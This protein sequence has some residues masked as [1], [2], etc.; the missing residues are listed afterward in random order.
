M[1]RFSLAFFLLC[2]SHPAWASLSSCAS[3]PGT[4]ISSLGGGCAKTDLNFTSLTLGTETGFTNSPTTGNIDFGASG[5]VISGT[6]STITPIDA[7]WTSP[8]AT[9]S[10]SG[11][12]WYVQSSSTHTATGSVGFQVT[13]N[14]G[15]AGSTPVTPAGDFWIINSL[16][17]VVNAGNYGTSSSGSATIVEQFCLNATTLAGCS[18]AKS[19]SI[20]ATI[21]AN[22]A[23]PTF[24]WQLGAF[25]GSGNSINLIAD[26]AN[27]VTSLYILDQVTLKNGGYG[28]TLS[29][30][31]A[32]SNQFDQTAVAPEPAPYLLLGTGLIGFA[33]LGRR[34]LR[35][36]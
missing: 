30:L 22:S 7:T 28:T 36:R 26:F 23:L 12:G 34:Q 6:P 35:R 10:P 11:N 24:T 31:D 18:S 1:K 19:G 25:S 13:G 9:S 17:L 2:S 21:G 8:A 14:N 15:A 4:S 16:E 29:Y 3:A 32:F 33:L 20:T 27:Q 5:G